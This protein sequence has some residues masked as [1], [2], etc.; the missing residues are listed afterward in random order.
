MLIK[1]LLEMEGLAE[2]LASTSSKSDKAGD[3]ICTGGARLTSSLVS[4]RWR[5]PLAL[6]GIALSSMIGTRNLVWLTSSLNLLS[7]TVRP[8]LKGH[9]SSR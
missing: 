2:R 4:Y 3:A 5:T 6:P 9:P 8:A 7:C 1:S